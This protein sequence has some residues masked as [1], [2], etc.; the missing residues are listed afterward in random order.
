MQS[1]ITKWEGAE[2]DIWRKP[3]PSFQEF[4]PRRVIQ[5]MLNPA[6]NKLLIRDTAPKVFIRGCSC[7]HPQVPRFQTPKG[8][9]MLSINHMD[10]TM[11]HCY[12]G[13]VLYQ[14]RGLFTSSVPRCQPRTGRPFWG[15]QSQACCVNSFLYSLGDLSLALFLR[16]R[17]A[18]GSIGP[19]REE[20]RS[21]VEANFCASF[22]FPII[23]FIFLLFF[24]IMSLHFL[25]IQLKLVSVFF[26]TKDSALA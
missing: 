10:C 20:G 15:Q 8:K 13:K 2:G 17:P 5:E 25:L 7:S 6:S 26:Y 11:S 16:V 19:D 12:L 3:S 18:L 23:P 9:Q 24:R 21:E 22:P 4:F 14:C 1:K